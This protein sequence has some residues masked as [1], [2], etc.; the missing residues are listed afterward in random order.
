ME[1]KINKLYLKNFKFIKDN[2]IKKI[3]F[4]KENLVILGGPNGYGKTTIFDAL[5]IIFKNKIEGIKK[6]TKSRRYLKD[7]LLLNNGD[8]SGILGIELVNFNKTI[9]IITKISSV[10]GHP[11]LDILVQKFYKEENLKIE[12]IQ[13]FKLKEYKEI[14]NISEIKG[15]ENFQEKNYN[16][17]NYISQKNY[18]YYLEKD[19]E[20]RNQIITELLGLSEIKDY[21]KYLDDIVSKKS[22]NLSLLKK[23]EKKEEEIK[24]L[25][26]ENN[27]NMTSMIK[28]LN[29]TID[30][31]KLK[32]LDFSK[33]EE[34]NNIKN[35][36]ELKTKYEIEL[37]NY[38]FLLLN[39]SKYC[40]YKKKKKYEKQL[41]IFNKISNIL[42]PDILEENIFLKSYH[43][44]DAYIEKEKK[45][46]E[47]LKKLKKLISEKLTLEKILDIEDEDIKIKRVE[48]GI[49]KESISIA[50]KKLDNNKKIMLELKK[51]REELF[52][53]HKN[54]EVKKIIKENECPY[55]GSKLKN[56][57]SMY[58][59]ILNRIDEN[60]SYEGLD[61][62]YKKREECLEINYTKILEKIKE[63]EE[64]EKNITK[65][66]KIEKN[67]VEINSFFEFCKNE[68]IEVSYF[69]L[70]EI[71]VK[72]I[73]EIS[74]DN[75]EEKIEKILENHI[76]D[77][78][79]IKE[80]NLDTM[81]EI[82]K[83]L[84]FKFIEIWNLL[85]AKN[86]DIIRKNV[87]ELIKMEKLYKKIEKISEIYIKR[88]KELED[89]VIPKLE[90]PLYIYTGKVLQDY[91]RGMGVFIK[92]ASKGIKFV[93][94]AGSDQ[95]LVNS[96]SS[97]QLSGFV[98]VLM[99]VM[100]KLFKERENGLDTLLVDDPF[101]TLDDVNMTSL[102]EILRRTF[103]RNQIILSSHEDKKIGYILY[104]YSK[105][106]L[107]AKELDVKNEFFNI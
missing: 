41:G 23:I 46:N 1:Y 84:E 24:E 82:E 36:K 90:I 72:K 66:E 33:F 79:K 22:I 83:Y 43:I 93:P 29:Q 39:N 99:L 71:L 64:N 26:S 10:Q 21:Q 38:K 98:V 30:E 55:C 19:E 104:K 51:Y 85:K 8:R 17:F 57:E 2:E 80:M 52:K 89:G 28:N 70:N 91:Q 9:S 49:L 87:I 73:K 45:K 59:E 53:L 4:G 61:D 106:N 6:I 16:L 12:D 95:D 5:E 7:S 3:E 14:K 15:L 100:N 47:K 20:E 96:F 60:N 54:E 105:F 65:I 18:C 86:Q 35:L 42:L 69:E 81:L 31:N 13:N 74:D 62:L 102:I 101:H 11:E 67:R 48:I 103:Y 58:K 44:N 40:N 107:K 63:L 76:L 50:E 68:K 56:L 97:G 77:E 27:I 94:E 25:I 37:E 92:K 34:V 32:I 78:K 88:K 75:F